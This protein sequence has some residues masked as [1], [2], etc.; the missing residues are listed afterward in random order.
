MKVRVN[1]VYTF[2]RSF[3]DAV[4][5]EHC[6]FVADGQRVRVVNLPGA[7]KCNTLGQAHIATVEGRFLGMCS[8]NSLFAD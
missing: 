7:P 3:A 4:M 6:P 5:R 2:R 8:T 1:S